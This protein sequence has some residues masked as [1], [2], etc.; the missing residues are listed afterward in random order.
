[1]SLMMSYVQVIQNE[2]HRGKSRKVKL[3]R[4]IDRQISEEKSDEEL[5]GLKARHVISIEKRASDN[6]FTTRRVCRFEGLLLEPI[7]SGCG[8]FFQAVYMP[9]RQYLE[10]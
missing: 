7:G 10:P 6:M 3:E 2:V 8:N 9:L 1:M 4:K 5:Q